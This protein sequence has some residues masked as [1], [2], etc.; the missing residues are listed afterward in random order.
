MIKPVEPKSTSRYTHPWNSANIAMTMDGSLV[1]TRI[2][3]GTLKLAGNGSS[4]TLQ[5][6]NGD[7]LIGSWNSAGITINKGSIS[8]I[9]D[10]TKKFVVTSEGV[11][12][13][14]G[15]TISGNVTINGGSIS[16]IT[17]NTKKF[18][19]SSAGVLTAMGATIS[20]NVTINGGSISIV[21]NNAKKFVVDSCGAL[22]ATSATISG[23][24][25]A[26]T[27]YVGY[28]KIKDGIMTNTT[29]GS[30]AILS[31]NKIGAGKAGYGV[32]ILRG[33][34]RD[35]G[36]IHS[37]GDGDYSTDKKYGFIQISNTGDPDECRGGIRIYGN[38]HIVWF[39]DDGDAVD[40]RYLRNIDEG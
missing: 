8:I 1:A 4:A 32:V 36:D 40:D 11:L 3:S 2:T 27:G 31:Y 39:D 10:S 6:Y 12:T 25:T 14:M 37:G 20:G 38:G 7:N 13:A 9:K 15:A 21:T 35:D 19:V 26:T 33:S 24:I 23:D 22:T 16:I 17:D 28:W 29:D 18:V 34:T 5:V 30:S